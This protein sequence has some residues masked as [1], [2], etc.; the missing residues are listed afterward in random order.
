MMK[1]Y[2]FPKLKM[3]TCTHGVV[4]FCRILSCPPT[5]NSL[6]IKL[7]DKAPL[8]YERAISL[9]IPVNSCQPSMSSWPSGPWE[10]RKYSALKRFLKAGA[11]SSTT[12][13]EV[14][15]R[16]E[17]LE[18]VWMTMHTCDGYWLRSKFTRKPSR[19][20]VQQETSKLRL[21]RPR[22]RENFRGDASFSHTTSHLPS[23]HI[24][25]KSMVGVFNQ[26][27]VPLAVPEP[28]AVDQTF[29]KRPF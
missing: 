8:N 18:S 24:E 17:G 28:L 27:D 23:H 3:E 16:F 29:A 14:E 12:K 22:S 15:L 5:Q 13:Y 26:V 9:E 25:I 11:R 19:D 21:S 7:F 10:R 2:V 4:N 20:A 6:F 1:H